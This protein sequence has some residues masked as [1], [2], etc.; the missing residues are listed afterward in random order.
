MPRATLLEYLDN[1]RRHASEPAYVHRRGYRVQHWS[2]GDVLAAAYRFAR[3]LESRGIGHDDKVLLWGENCAEWIAA[4][5]GCVLRGAVVV[6]I[7]KIAAPDFA[8]RV[9]QQVDARL[10]VS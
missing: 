7:D 2:Y 6:P 5:F 10:C 3:E 8:Q 9:A 1:F 4:F